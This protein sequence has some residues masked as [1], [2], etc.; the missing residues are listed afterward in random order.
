M[1]NPVDLAIRT[2]TVGAGI[3]S[4]IVYIVFVLT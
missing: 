3:V 4:L 1:K 2:M